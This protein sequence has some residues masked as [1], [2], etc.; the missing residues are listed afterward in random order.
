MPPETLTGRRIPQLLAEARLYIAPKLGR[1]RVNLFVPGRRCFHRILLSHGLAFVHRSTPTSEARAGA[2]CSLG[3]EQTSELADGSP[4]TEL[5]CGGRVDALRVDWKVG[6][7]P[8]ID[9]V[10]D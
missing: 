2:G 6:A 9:R 10:G 3:S 8:T 4:G 7:C 1:L 5:F